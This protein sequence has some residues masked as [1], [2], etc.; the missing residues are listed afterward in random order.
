MT[1][2]IIAKLIKVAHKLA[3]CRQNT[4]YYQ[5]KQVQESQINLVLVLLIF[6][7]SCTVLPLVP[8]VHIA[9]FEQSKETV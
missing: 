6:S 7:E 5:L 2:L 8:D 3:A 4:K 1:I 9:V